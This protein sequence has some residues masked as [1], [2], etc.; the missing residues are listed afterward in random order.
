MLALHDRQ[1]NLS[2]G[3]AAAELAMG[4]QCYVS[5]QPAEAGDEPIGALRYVARAFASRAAI[6]IAVPTRPTI[7]DVAGGSALVMPVVPFGEV[8]FD[9]GRWQRRTG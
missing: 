3:Q 1:S 7:R 8:R 5:A 6:A 9:H 2:R 4:E